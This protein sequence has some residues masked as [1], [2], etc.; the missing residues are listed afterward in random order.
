MG[1]HSY[2][3]LKLMVLIISQPKAGKLLPVGVKT[4]EPVR[5][6][7]KGDRVTPGARSRRD[8]PAKPFCCGTFRGELNETEA[9]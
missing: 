8:R 9:R 6:P 1:L 2:S 3:L 7:L 4:S 5:R